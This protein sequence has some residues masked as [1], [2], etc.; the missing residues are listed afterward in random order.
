MAT[1]KDQRYRT[2]MYD[3]LNSDLGKMFL[4]ALAVGVVVVFVLVGFRV[5]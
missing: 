5:I 2:Q 1:D 3:F 4:F